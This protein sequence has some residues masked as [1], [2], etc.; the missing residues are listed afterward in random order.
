[1]FQVVVLSSALAQVVSITSLQLPS[2]PTLT[3][4]PVSFPTITA[5]IDEEAAPFVKE[6][7]NPSDPFIGQV[8]QDQFSQWDGTYKAVAMSCSNATNAQCLAFCT[9]SVKTTTRVESGKNPYKVQGQSG[10]TGTAPPGCE[11]N[12]AGKPMFTFE[13][14]AP[15]HGMNMAGAYIKLNTAN[16]S[17][18]IGGYNLGP[19]REHCLSLMKK[20]SA[21]TPAY[22]GVALAVTLVSLLF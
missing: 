9:T 10:A 22:A 19:R 11:C 16:S 21:V 5:P 13:A 1:M 17:F 14:S 12:S 6:F 8:A 18:V 15:F 20:S 4:P 2:M 3:M 7:V